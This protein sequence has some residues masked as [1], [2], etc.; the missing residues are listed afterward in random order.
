M[1]LLAENGGDLR[2]AM[3]DAVRS[4]TR[5]CGPVWIASDPC[6]DGILRIETVHIRYVRVSAAGTVAVMRA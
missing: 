4:R 3:G 6:F 2:L 5:A 1:D